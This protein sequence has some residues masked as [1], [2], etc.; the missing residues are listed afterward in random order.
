MKVFDVSHHQGSGFPFDKMKKAG[1]AG[2]IIRTGDGVKQD[3]EFENNFTAATEAG[4]KVG[5]YHFSRAMN[6]EEAVKESLLVTTLLDGR[7]PHLGVFLD[8]EVYKSK[9]VH[10]TAHKAFEERL[11]RL[12]G[13]THTGLYTSEYFYNH[14]FDKDYFAGK[15][16]WIAKYSKNAPSIGQ[17]ICGWQYTSKGDPTLPYIK[18][19]DLSIFFYEGS[20]ESDQIGTGEQKDYIDV[21][22]DVVAGK[23]GNG[24]ERIA[25]L[26]REG[27][28]PEK[29][30]D[31]VNDYYK[32]GLDII[33]GKYYNE[34]QRSKLVEAKGYDYGL[35]RVV[36]NN[37]CGK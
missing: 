31:I 27:Y 14:Y 25:A 21:V 22:S 12:T 34:P 20:E 10:T 7:L 4:L 29:V 24:D 35:A 33:A 9:N 8:M 18:P 2:V 3:R 36:V 19:L 32:L 13:I 23:Y 30:R 1:Y 17:L 28:D 37:I 26:S 6:T 5:I 15:H 16:K 11:Y